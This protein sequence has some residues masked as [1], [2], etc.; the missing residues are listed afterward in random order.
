MNRV[1]SDRDTV[2]IRRRGSEDVALIAAAELN[3]LMETAHLLRSPRNAERLTIALERARRAEMAP[4][5]V[6]SLRRE[7]G[8]DAAP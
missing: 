1:V 2:I 7:L 4:E 8:L 5:T 6:E 3:S